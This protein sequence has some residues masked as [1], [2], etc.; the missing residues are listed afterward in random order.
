MLSP[1]TKIYNVQKLGELFFL[2]IDP[3]NFFSIYSQS[4]C[5]FVIGM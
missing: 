4:Y 2:G 1:M 3:S 5:L